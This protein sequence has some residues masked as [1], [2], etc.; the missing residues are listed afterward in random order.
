MADD[1]AYRIAVRFETAS[2]RFVA[3]AIELDITA[4]AE[5]RTEALGQVE[6][7]IEARFESAATAGETLPEAADSHELSLDPLAI[8]LAEPL[9]RELHFAAH[10]A[11]LTDAQLAEQLLAHSVGLLNRGRRM[12]L[13]PRQA[14]PRDAER[15]EG[16]EEQP[17]VG[18]QAQ[19]ERPSNGP[20]RKNRRPRGRHP[21]GGRRGGYRP[22]VEDQA[23][24]LAYVRDNEKGGRRR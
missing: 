4:E 8:S 22:D 18:N 11:G 24:F 9:R 3:E 17:E 10:R 23:A 21:A 19:S 6:K 13:P 7:L 1:R 16:A 20:S 15:E 14:A 12:S 5:S 2:E